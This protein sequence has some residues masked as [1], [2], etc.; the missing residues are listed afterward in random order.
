MQFSGKI[1]SEKVYF[2]PVVFIFGRMGSRDIYSSG[3]SM[4]IKCV[5]FLFCSQWFFP[6]VLDWYAFLARSVRFQMIL[7]SGAEVANSFK[8]RVWTR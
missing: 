2:L 7:F 3:E 4:W 8:T 5:G 1:L 6:G